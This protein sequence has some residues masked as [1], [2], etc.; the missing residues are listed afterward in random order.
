[1]ASAVSLTG[2]TITK[3]PGVTCTPAVKT[4]FP[5]AVTNVSPGTPQTAVVTLDFTGC[6]P[7][8]TFT[9]RFDYSYGDAGGGTYTGNNSFYNIMR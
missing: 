5:V 1:M 2:M 4:T 3:G 8:N 6:A 9:V 7:T